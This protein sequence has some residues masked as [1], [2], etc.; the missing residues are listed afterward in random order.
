[1]SSFIG[2]TIRAA[3][4]VLALG[5]SLAASG[6]VHAEGMFRGG[7]MRHEHGGM[8][9]GTGLAMGL[10]AGLFAGGLS[11]G[12]IQ[13][14]TYRNSETCIR[15]GA[16]H[17]HVYN[18]GAGGQEVQIIKPPKLHRTGC[19]GGRCTPVRYGNYLLWTYSDGAG[20]QFAQITDANQNPVGVPAGSVVGGYTIIP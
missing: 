16:C 18:N 7:M 5:G 17:V 4:A 14:P 12:Y 3:L 19:R 2:S 1:M 8:G 13:D 20:N 15:F 11:Y 10:A 6:P 9:I